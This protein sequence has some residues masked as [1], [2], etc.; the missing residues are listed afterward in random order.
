MRKMLLA[1]ACL[2]ALT[3]SAAAKCPYDEISQSLRRQQES[4]NNQIDS[5]EKNK[6]LPSCH[7]V[8]LLEKYVELSKVIRQYSLQCGPVA[9]KGFCPAGRSCKWHATNCPS[10]IA[11]NSGSSVRQ[12]SNA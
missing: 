3:G 5:A 10:C 7:V 6:S 9:A 8:P 11:R 1:G 2:A 4:L 12:R